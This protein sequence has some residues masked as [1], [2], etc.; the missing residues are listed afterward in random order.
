MFNVWWT[1]DSQQPTKNKLSKENKIFYQ[2][3][4]FDEHTEKSDLNII[5]SNQTWIVITLF[6]LIWNQTKFHSVHQTKQKKSA[7][8]N[9]NMG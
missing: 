9:P 4:T 6:R 7:I 8:Y 1:T 2:K 3:K 5:K